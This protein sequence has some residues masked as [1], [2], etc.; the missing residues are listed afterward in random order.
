MGSGRGRGYGLKL[1]RLLM[2]GTVGSWLVLSVSIWSVHPCY[3]L[4]VD[5]RCVH[6]NQHG[7]HLYR[8]CVVV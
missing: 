8:Q 5:I 4:K 6:R 3:T 7:H 2:R 1:R